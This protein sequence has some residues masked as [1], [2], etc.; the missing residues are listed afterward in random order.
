MNKLVL[1]LYWKTRFFLKDL[2]S[3]EKPAVGLV[4]SS[5][6]KGGLEQIVLNLY[7]GYKK[8]GIK[9]FI[10]CQSKNAKT[11]V[12]RLDETTDI[13]I[14]DNNIN[15]FFNYC[16]KN[17]IRILHYHTNTFLMRYAKFL[18]FKIYYTI[19]NVYVW[20]SNDDWNKY[21]QTMRYCDQIVAVSEWTKKYFSS[22]TNIVDIEVVQNGIDLSN[23]NAI[24]KYAFTRKKLGIKESDKVFV[25]LASINEAKHQVALI[26]IMERI[27]KVRKDIFFLLVGN[28]L[29]YKYYSLLKKKLAKSH[30]SRYIKYIG[31]LSQHDLSSFLR[32]IP[33]AAIL[34]SLYEGSSLSVIECIYCGL[35]V[36]V[37][38]FSVYD[39]DSVNSVLLPVSPAYDDINS[40]TFSKIIKLSKIKNNSNTD[41]VARTVIDLA[42]THSKYK[43]SFSK[44]N[45]S[46]FSTETMVDKYLKIFNLD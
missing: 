28:V 31:Y 38:N 2:L 1:F 44:I 20:F 23:L 4:V 12:E 7:H 25:H 27:L 17:N 34:P 9:A 33:N 14:V 42:D 35:P 10:L 8:R 39:D 6:D 5:F 16:Y 11:F 43:E 45:F 15:D 22:K 36:I 30:A 18:G 46:Q 24:D 41:E 29:N 37:S 21:K 3:E 40:V 13:R 26:G 32:T 19:H